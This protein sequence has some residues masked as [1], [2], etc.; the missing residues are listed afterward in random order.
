M[1]VLDSLQRSTKTIVNKR[2]ECAPYDKTR[3]GVVLTADNVSHFCSVR[4]D[5][6]VYDKIPVQRYLWLQ[7]GDIVKI[8]FPSGNPSQMFVSG[9]KSC[10]ITED[11]MTELETMLGIT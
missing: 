10:L 2:I 7:N 8:V 6:V 9:A 11:E 4:V 1:N 3:N 5:G